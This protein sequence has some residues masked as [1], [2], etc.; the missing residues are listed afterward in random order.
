MQGKIQRVSLDSPSLVIEI[1]ILRAAE[2]KNSPMVCNFCFGI[3]NE[4]WVKSK[5]THCIKIDRGGQAGRVF[6]ESFFGQPDFCF[7]KSVMMS[8]SN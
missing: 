1:L 6:P 4:N 7:V 2:L 3:G 5:E 8:L